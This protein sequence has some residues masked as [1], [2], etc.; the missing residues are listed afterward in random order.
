VNADREA[1]RDRDG[2][3]NEPL[4]YDRLQVVDLLCAD[5][6]GLGRKRKGH[7]RRVF[8]LALRRSQYDHLPPRRRGV[9]HRASETKGGLL[10][11]FGSAGKE[12]GEM[13]FPIGVA[14]DGRNRIIV[15]DTSKTTASRCSAQRVS[16][17][18]SSVQ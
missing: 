14:V 7:E 18:S 15:T 9:R 10:F 4:A 11:K 2:E 13:S 1:D 8:P 16:F 17:S 12:N 6:S 5:S 3:E